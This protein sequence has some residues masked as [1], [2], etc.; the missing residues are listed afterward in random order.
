MNQNND[1]ILDYVE[2]KE[3]VSVLE[4]NKLLEVAEYA[5]KELLL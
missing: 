2:R 3:S 4:D 1:N 5:K